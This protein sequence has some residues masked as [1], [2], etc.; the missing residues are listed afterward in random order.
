M[1]MLDFERATGHDPGYSL[2]FSR[3]MKLAMVVVV[4]LAFVGLGL[5]VDGSLTFACGIE[6]LFPALIQMLAVVVFELATALEGLVRKCVLILLK[7]V[8]PFV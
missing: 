5:G 1:N 3:V 8:S 7:S 4:I 6:G 2:V